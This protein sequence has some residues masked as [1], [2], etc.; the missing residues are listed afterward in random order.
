MKNPPKEITKQTHMEE[1]ILNFSRPYDK[2]AA[3]FI[4]KLSLADKFYFITLLDKTK[5]SPQ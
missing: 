4:Y 5:K 3:R 1:K 2:I